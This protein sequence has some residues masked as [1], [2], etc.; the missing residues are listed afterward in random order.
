MVKVAEDEHGRLID[1]EHLSE[2]SGGLSR[3]V[4]ALGAALSQAM[5]R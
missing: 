2:C 3:C 5:R 1:L 4:L